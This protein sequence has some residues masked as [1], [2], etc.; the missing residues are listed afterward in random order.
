MMP[1]VGVALRACEMMEITDRSG[2]QIIMRFSKIYSPEKIGAIIAKAKTYLW[3]QKNPK[4]AFMKAVG[5]INRIEKTCLSQ[6]TESPT[7]V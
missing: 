4:A 5:E 7:T 2:Q 1:F 6:K 3:W